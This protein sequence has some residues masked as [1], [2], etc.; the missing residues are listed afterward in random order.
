[1]FR[2]RLR[3]CL[4]YIP[5][6]LLHDSFGKLH[7]GLDSE[8]NATTGFRISFVITDILSDTSH[9]FPTATVIHHGRVFRPAASKDPWQIFAPPPL[10]TGAGTVI[11]QSSQTW[12]LPPDFSFVPELVI[13]FLAVFQQM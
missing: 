3:L 7:I 4:F 9:D 2:G 11:R 12:T 10:L 13:G 1:M 5:T 6:T 8:K